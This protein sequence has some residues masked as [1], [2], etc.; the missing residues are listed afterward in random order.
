MAF[1][2]IPKRSKVK[3][4]DGGPL[5]GKRKAID[6]PR[7]TRGP[8]IF[9]LADKHKIDLPLRLRFEVYNEGNPLD[10]WTTAAHKAVFKLF[11]PNMITYGA[12]ALYN[13]NMFGNYATAINTDPRPYFFNLMSS[14]YSRFYCYATTVKYHIIPSGSEPFET[15]TY[16]ISTLDKTYLGITNATDPPTQWAAATQF[17]SRDWVPRSRTN[18]VST[19]RSPDGF[20]SDYFECKNLIDT[21]GFEDEADYYTVSSISAVAAFQLPYYGL[22]IKSLGTTQSKLYVIFD[23][24]FHTIWAQ[25]QNLSYTS[26]GFTEVY[27][28]DW[29]A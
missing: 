10:G 28:G 2:S 8:G 20:Q 25:P 3:R 6:V 21:E 29:H 26:L 19:W 14:K 15:F 5:K 11:T 27:D 1:R 24:T 7:I 12:N 13:G 18:V 9:L 4:R 22:I 17:P 16:A 23:I